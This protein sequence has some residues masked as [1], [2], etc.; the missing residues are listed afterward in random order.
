[1]RDY[2]RI[3]T[4]M[5]KKTYTPARVY[6]RLSIEMEGA[7]LAGSV[8]DKMGVQSVGQKVDDYN[9]GDHDAFNFSWGEE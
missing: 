2:Y 3:F 9:F 7:L 8:V 1:M 5:T 6:E 4:I